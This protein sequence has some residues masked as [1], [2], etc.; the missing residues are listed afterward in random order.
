MAYGLDHA[1]AVMAITL[2]PAEA[3]GLADHLGSVSPG[4][5]ANLVLWSG[6]PL[7]V[8]S[9]A[10]RIWIDGIEQPLDNRQR[11]LVRRYLD[12]PAAPAR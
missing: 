9:V 2:T 11:Q 8:T 12:E 4:K 3:F 6:D 7:E 1:A 5:R 10:E